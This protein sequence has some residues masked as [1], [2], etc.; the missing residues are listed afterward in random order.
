MIDKYQQHIHQG[1]YVE[2][3]DFQHLSR[4]ITNGSQS[5]TVLPLIRFGCAAEEVQDS[6]AVEYKI[7]H[8]LLGV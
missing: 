1:G 8:V 7:S 3:L 6:Q 2:L 5:D 4:S